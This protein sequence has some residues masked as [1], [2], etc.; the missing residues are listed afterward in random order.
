VRAIAQLILLVMVAVE[1]AATLAASKSA[2]G[3][4]IEISWESCVEELTGEARVFNAS[5]P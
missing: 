2:P 5:A 4:S 3:R 1:I